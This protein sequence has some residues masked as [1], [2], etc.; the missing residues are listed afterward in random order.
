MGESLS[1]LFRLGHQGQSWQ[2][3]SSDP[4]PSHFPSGVCASLHSQPPST[5][6]DGPRGSSHTYVPVLVLPLSPSPFCLRAC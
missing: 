1:C 4:D 6:T 5:L 2:G 3:S